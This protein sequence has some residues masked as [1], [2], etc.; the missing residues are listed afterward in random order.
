MRYQATDKTYHVHASL[1]KI[2]RTISK[3]KEKVL[4]IVQSRE[5]NTILHIK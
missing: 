3:I 2:K 5:C 1:E 4:H